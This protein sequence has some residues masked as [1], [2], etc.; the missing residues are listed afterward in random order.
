[1]GG[2]EGW[3]GGD[4]PPRSPL[5]TMPP[6]VPTL[7][8]G[9]GG[10]QPGRCS[11]LLAGFALLGISRELPEIRA[12]FQPGNDR[13]VCADLQPGASSRGDQSGRSWL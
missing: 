1:M 11:G 7:L 8:W 2:S 9:S 4:L 3:G 10:D 6:D 13:T 12:D 5:P